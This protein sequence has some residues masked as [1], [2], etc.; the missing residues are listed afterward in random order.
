MNTQVDKMVKSEFQR[1][2]KY[3]SLKK[4]LDLLKNETQGVVKWSFPLYSTVLHVLRLFHTR[5]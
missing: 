5:L 2:P 4:V 3:L 1:N